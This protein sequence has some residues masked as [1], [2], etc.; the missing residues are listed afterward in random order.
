MSS[1]WLGS[2]ASWASALSVRLLKGEEFYL[3]EFFDLH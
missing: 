1:L 3:L 2:S